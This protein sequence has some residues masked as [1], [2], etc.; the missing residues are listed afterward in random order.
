MCI[1]DSLHT[2]SA[3]TRTPEAELFALGTITLRTRAIHTVK[4]LE[5]RLPKGRDVYKRQLNDHHSGPAVNEALEH[6]QQG[7][8]VQRVQPDGGLVE[9]KH[10][11]GLP[12][13]LSLIH[14]CYGT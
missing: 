6:A 2:L 12:F 13:A 7:A 10:G 9:Y 4:P 11:V 8:H 14:I 5:V 3:R 1:R